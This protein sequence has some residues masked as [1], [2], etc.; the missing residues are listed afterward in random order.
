MTTASRTAETRAADALAELLYNLGDTDN[1][2]HWCTEF[3][4]S[5]PSPIIRAGAFMRVGF[6]PTVQVDFEDGS[7]LHLTV[8]L[9]KEPRQP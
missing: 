5:F 7:V 9:I 8:T 1:C 6:L 3:E 2:A 4:G